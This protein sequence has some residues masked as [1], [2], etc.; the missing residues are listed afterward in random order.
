MFNCMFI[1][2]TPFETMTV[3]LFQFSES[4]RM[5]LA[6]DKIQVGFPCFQLLNGKSTLPVKAFV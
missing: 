4:R 6:L 2:R 3:G 1:V 5:D